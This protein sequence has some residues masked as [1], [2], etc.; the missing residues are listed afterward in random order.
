ML[1]EFWEIDFPHSPSLTPGGDADCGSIRCSSLWLI[2]Q[3]VTSV[4]LSDYALL[5][6]SSLWRVHPGGDLSLLT[7]FITA[8]HTPSFPGALQLPCW[9]ELPSVLITQP[10]HGILCS[11]LYCCSSQLGS[12]QMGLLISLLWSVTEDNEFCALGEKLKNHFSATPILASDGENAQD[13]QSVS[14]G[15]T[16][17]TAAQLKAI[18]T[19]KLFWRK[20]IEMEQLRTWKHGCL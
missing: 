18:I 16:S 3:H 12:K 19:T 8:S 17:S 15:V 10:L 7:V 5:Q 2:F 11:Y 20:L 14:K 4:V 9:Y 13:Y 6:N 1:K